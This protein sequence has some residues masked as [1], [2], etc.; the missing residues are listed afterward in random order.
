[1]KSFPSL[2]ILCVLTLAISASAFGQGALT[3]VVTDS[4]THE[5]LVGVNVVLLGTGIGNATNIEGEYK[6]MNIPL[7][8]YEV[9][10]SCIGYEVKIR[11]VDFTKTADQ[12]LNF[13]LNQTVIQGQEVVI[14][15]QMRGQV[16]AVNQQ[17]SSKTIVNVVSEERIKELPDAN[18]AE[19]IGRL[20]GVALQRSGGEANKIVLRGM[21]SEFGSV[22]VDGVRIPPTDA[23]SRGVDLSMVSQG[24]LAGIELFKALTSDKDADAIAGT[25]NL[26][27]KNAPSERT[28]QVDTK[29]AYNKLNKTAKQYDLAVK[30]G[31]RFFNNLLGVQIAGN[32]EQRD[33]SSENVGIDYDLN[34]DSKFTDYIITDL[35]LQYVDEVRKRG[36]GSILLDFNTPDN[37][38]IKFS[39][40]YSSTSR[41][42]ITYSRNY[43]QTAVYGPVY[44]DRDQEQ[45]INTFNS[46]LHGKNYIFGL[47]ADWGLSF[48]QSRSQYPYDYYIDFFEPSNNL[49][50]G[51]KAIPQS[52]LKGPPE[53]YIDYAYNNFSA[54]F[55]DWSYY[56]AQ[57]NSDKEKTAYLDLTQNYTFGSMFFGE[58]KVGGK[59]RQKARDKDQS[60]LTSN[61]EIFGFD[62]DERWPDGTIHPKNFSGSRFA[63]DQFPGGKIL[64]SYFLDPSPPERSLYDKYRLYPMITNDAIRSWWDINQNGISGSVSEY[65]VDGQAAA[66]SYGVI[67]RVSAGYLMNTLNVG[68]DVT[69]IAG[70]RVESENNDYTSRFSPIPL[71]G[72]PAVGGVLK[73]TSAKYSEV[74]WL[75]NVQL[76]LKPFDF[77]NVRLA[78]YQAL[79]RPDFNYRL[80]E[81]V[82]RN[83]ATA[84]PRGVP[85]EYGTAV[86]Y[87]NPNLTAGKAWNF[88][89]NASFFSNTIGLFSLSA[90]YKNIDNMYHLA[91]FILVEGP[92]TANGQK[93]LD[94]NG[95]N[96]KNP[97]NSNSTSYYISY[98]YNSS[99]P[100][101]IW[102][103]EIEHQANLGFLPGLLK[104]IVLSY[105]VSIVRSETYIK[106]Y[107]MTDSIWVVTH[108]RFGDQTNLYLTP[109]YFELKQKMEGQPELYGNVALG[110]DIGGFSARLS[111]FFQSEY[112]SAYSA[113]GKN[114]IV[115]NKLTRLDLALKQQITSNLAIMVNVNNLTNADESTA[116]KSRLAGWK[117]QN[118][119]TNYGMTAD[120]AVRLTF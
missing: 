33:R 43:P 107:A 58:L 71:S 66:G 89:A 52:N 24:S 85:A 6:I 59:Y 45:N 74:E 38:T 55:L 86:Y 22:S 120:A 47:T 103:F 30:Y 28:I 87:G 37:G 53:S 23:D 12:R 32:L 63:N 8:T 41:N 42:F 14:T 36:G 105:N 50:S 100:T 109:E 2:A 61:H 60:Q 40:V 13:Q 115:T 91:N 72:Y 119:S 34:Y 98:P 111:L 9:R 4:L 54:A 108:S 46:S 25:V 95:I 16:A 31:E 94:N 90:Y 114:D 19:A 7:K 56:R 17:V 68:Q 18:A 96:W 26:V 48:A 73:D 35:T 113:D 106:S 67:E 104:N 62:S 49:V 78:A 29:G 117:L 118:S 83:S 93:Y 112:T 88:E 44:S 76:A 102:G 64:L 81:V 15:G 39:N 92:L 75:P 77:M 82:A 97:F 3:G 70:V 101:K 51:M 57:N 5:K 65:V 20:P 21:S 11:K 116:Y 80:T 69:F 27:T 79:A 84:L 1:M 110:Y 99:K 10:V